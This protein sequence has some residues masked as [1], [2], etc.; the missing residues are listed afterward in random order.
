MRSYGE[1]GRKPEENWGHLSL[2]RTTAFSQRRPLSCFCR[3]GTL[4]AG[5]EPDGTVLARTKTKR[6]ALVKTPGLVAYPPAQR[7]G[8]VVEATF[9][10]AL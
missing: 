9:E 6:E 8:K 3:L 10:A 2:D 1:K 4:T 5:R 7:M